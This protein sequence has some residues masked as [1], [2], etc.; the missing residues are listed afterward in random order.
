MEPSQRSARFGSMT[1]RRVHI[2]SR[3]RRYRHTGG[4]VATPGFESVSPSLGVQS[5]FR[6]LIALLLDTVVLRLSYAASHWRQP[7]PGTAP[8]R[9]ASSR[10]APPAPPADI[11]TVP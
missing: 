6:T 4:L 9:Y 1:S 11:D 8:T 10:P 7:L 3:S 2:S 5:G